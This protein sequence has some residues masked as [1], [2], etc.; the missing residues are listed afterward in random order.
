MNLKRTELMSDINKIVDEM[1]IRLDFLSKE[2]K[3]EIETLLRC[4]DDVQ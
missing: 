1:K 4:V 3:Y 2:S